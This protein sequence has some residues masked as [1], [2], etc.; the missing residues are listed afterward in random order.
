MK[1]R[2]RNPSR[3]P[4]RLLSFISIAALL[5]LWSCASFPGP[6]ATDSSLIVGR[7]TLEGSGTGYAANGADGTYNA[8][9]PYGAVLSISNATTG[10]I[11]QLQTSAPNG[12]FTLPNVAPGTYTVVGFWAQ[13]ETINAWV[14][15]QTRFTQ[16]P[17]FDVQPGHVAN[18]GEI[19]WDFTY[20]LMRSTSAASYTFGNSLSDV[21]AAFARAYAGSAWEKLP[22]DQTAVSGSGSAVSSAYALQPKGSGNRIYIP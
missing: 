19:H 2:K 3:R 10:A 18:L 13:V 6:T 22:L 1:I 15:V 11:L 17:T 7:L 4:T 20:D 21:Q 9:L 8:K 12:L 5:F 14:T 16:G